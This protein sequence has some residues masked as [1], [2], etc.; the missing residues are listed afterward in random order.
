MMYGESVAGFSSAV[1]Q[2]TE[3]FAAAAAFKISLFTVIAFR[4][5]DSHS[6]R[7]LIANA[8]VGCQRIARFVHMV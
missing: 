5:N 2:G 1:R 8:P 6:D 3:S 4:S 7:F